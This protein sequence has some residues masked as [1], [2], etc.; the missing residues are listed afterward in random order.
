MIAYV[1]W[2]RSRP[3]VAVADYQE[4]LLAFHESLVKAQ[5]AGAQRTTVFRVAEL[6]WPP[7]SE[8]GFEEWHL[9]ENSGA[10][11]VLNEAA[12]SGDRLQPHN[13]VAAI[14]KHAA[15]SHPDLRPDSLSAIEG[16][17]EPWTDRLS[18]VYLDG[19]EQ[20]QAH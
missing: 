12:V 18:G 14:P 2:H 20:D 15:R 6:P 13:R 5:P 16:S 3:E 7:P 11:D 1:F 17:P 4:A 10:L 8:P 9:L 19:R